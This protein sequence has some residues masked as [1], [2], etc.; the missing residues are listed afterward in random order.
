[1]ISKGFMVSRRPLLRGMTRHWPVLLKAVLAMAVVGYIVAWVE[2]EAVVSAFAAADWRW[3]ALAA[4]LLPV[5]LLLEVGVWHQLVRQIAPGT[6]VRTSGEAALCGHA[7]GLFTPAR[8]GELAGRAFYIPTGDRWTLGAAAVTERLTMVAVG[9]VAGVPALLWFLQTHA[10]SAPTVLYLALLYASGVTL[11][12]LLGLAFPR[13]AWQ[14]LHRL[15]WKRLSHASRFLRALRGA[16]H[17]WLIGYSVARYGVFAVQ[18][19]LALWAFVPELPFT[20][21]LAG[22][23]LVFMTKFLL[24][25]LTLG[26]LGIREGAAVYFFGWMGFQHAAVLNASLVIFGLTVLAPALLGLPYVLALKIQGPPPP[27]VEAS[28]PSSSIVSSPASDG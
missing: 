21:A 20:T 8:V 7:L 3:I 9:G 13:R 26:D 27:T 28:P 14:G 11:A 1:M 4:V 23:A 16:I 25:S 6:S 19:L 2:V 17:A 12:L 10:P 15:R 18:F 5:N 22:I 24:P